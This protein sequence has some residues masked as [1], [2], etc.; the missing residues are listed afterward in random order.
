MHV[1]FLAA[2]YPPEKTAD[3]HLEQDLIEGMVKRGWKVDI[4][5]PTPTRG[6]SKED[7]EVYKKIKEEKQFDGNVIVHRFWAPQ[8]RTKA[9]A[10]ALR[11]LWC[12]IRQIHIGKRIDNVD[13][14]Y[15]N[16]TPPIQGLTAKAIKKKVG[17]S[18]VYSLQDLFPDSLVTAGIATKD[19]ISY[20]IGLKIEKKTY[21][22]C[23]AIITL[24]ESFRKLLL[25]KGV[26]PKQIDV[27]Y[28]WINTEDVYPIKKEDNKL[29]DELGI[30]RDK[31]TILYAGNFGK[32]QNI[33]YL[34]DAAKAVIDIDIYQFVLFGAGSEFDRIK[35]RVATENISNCSV[36]PLMPLNRVGEVY[37][38]GDIDIVCNALGISMVG[39]PSKTWTIM[40]T[41]TP[42]VA[43]VD[44]NSELADIIKQSNSGWICDPS[45]TSDFVNVLKHITNQPS[46][47][48]R[49]GIG[50]R[51]LAVNRF[52]KQQ[53]VN[54]YLDII[55]SA[56]SKH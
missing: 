19:S 44:S 3:T 24:S 51:I 34:V 40:S 14:I 49:Y 7:I 18:F 53:A 56:S 47:L 38:M 23:N 6:C 31:F 11:Y 15:C 26:A 20:R 37:S 10:R 21:E 54:A 28:N 25:G 36:F 50:A 29:F 39:M 13:V 48:V 17:S 55:S 41:G 46:E 22:A 16:S 33:D 27:V 12:C 1:L 4:L 9:V 30:K 32:S 43:I 45:N 2:Y 52:G 5:C 42:V 35:Q 8:E